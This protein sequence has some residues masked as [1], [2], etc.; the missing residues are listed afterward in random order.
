MLRTL[1][2][3]AMTCVLALAVV[4]LTFRA[5]QEAPA[6]FRF[7]NGTEPKTL[8]PQIM[9]GQPEG[10]VADAIF[11]GLTRRD[12]RTLHPVPGVARSWEVSAD[13]RRYVFH[14]RPDARW[15]DGRPVTAHDFSYAWRRLQDPK[16]GAEYAYILH[17]VEGARAFNRYG[18]QAEALRELLAGAFQELRKA[19]PLGLDTATWAAFAERH[20]LPDLVQGSP[21]R[22]LRNL[23]DP[24][25]DPGGDPGRRSLGPAQLNAL[26][27]AL[28]REAVRRAALFAQADRRFGFDAGVYARD[29]HTLVVELEAPTPYFLELTAFYPAFPT[30]RWVVEPESG[31]GEESV[32]RG[33]FL[34]ETIVSNGPFELASWRVNDRIRLVRSESY[35]GR[36]DVA[37]ETIDVLPVEN[38]TTALNLYLTG[39]ADWLPSS[40]PQDLVEELRQ[41]PDFYSGPG[42]MV[43]YYR[44][45]T[46]RPPFDDARVREAFSLGID[47]QLIVD[48]VLGLGQLPASHL[49]PPGMPGYRPPASLLGLDVER[50]RHL[51]DQAGHPGGEGIGEIGILYNTS[52]GHK[53]IAEVIA[54]QLRR[55]LGLRVEA[56]NQEWQSYLATLRAGDYQVA[57]A[58]WIGDYRDPNTFLDLWVTNGGNNQTGW[59][60]PLF[61]QLI[62]AAANPAGFVSSPG[63]DLVRLKDPERAGADVAAVREAAH[64]K[65]RAAAGARLRLTLLAEAEAIL[66]QDEFPI[67]PIYFYVVSGLV[68]PGI[69]GFYS[70]LE[71]EDG[72]R[73]ANLQDL[74]PLRAISLGASASVGRGS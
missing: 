65:G 10:R 44:F 43:Y 47:R 31:N 3:I 48:E 34:P 18:S 12:A 53:K 51:L 61:D 68:R 60:H 13:G 71:F 62:A 4:G 20:G 63:F 5:S 15:T 14:L 21:D 26:E 49:V 72:T 27:S 37:L 36:E 39:G 45:N 56:Y 41:R 42:L 17:M 67:M 2:G 33:W 38:A 29:D 28:A 52:E 35:W 24:G 40:Y 50:A 66:V 46:R 22:T 16:T 8:D 57:R 55:N 30:P 69:E 11:E 54:D 73:G 59:S 25:G 19:N 23:T 9:T 6:D 70:E 1:A 32:R 7:I 64:A 58:G 74:H